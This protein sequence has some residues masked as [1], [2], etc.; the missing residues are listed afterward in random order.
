MPAES[1]TERPMPFFVVWEAPS[2]SDAQVPVHNVL[3]A[4]EAFATREEAEDGIRLMFEI[5]P[6]YDQ[7]APDFQIIEAPTIGEAMSQVTGFAHPG[8]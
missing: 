8:P 3:A 2:R 7:P 4:R 6:A 1:A 5:G